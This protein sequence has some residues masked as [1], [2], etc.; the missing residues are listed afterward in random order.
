MANKTN[1][2]AS[3]NHEGGMAQVNADSSNGI[4]EESHCL[5]QDSD[6]KEKMNRSAPDPKKVNPCPPS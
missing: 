1:V 4:P 5:L 3:T 2:I 6:K